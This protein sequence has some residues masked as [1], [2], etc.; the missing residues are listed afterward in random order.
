MDRTITLQSPPDGEFALMNYRC[1]RQEFQPPFRVQCDP[2]LAAPTRL[3]ITVTVRAE[4][5]R[6][7][8]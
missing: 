6:V 7:G 3:D 1:T 5:P 2:V 4:Y 8:C